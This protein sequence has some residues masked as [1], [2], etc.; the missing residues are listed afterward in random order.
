LR[1]NCVFSTRNCC[2]SQ[3]AFLQVLSLLG[4]QVA[5]APP[6]LLS[7]QEVRYP[8]LDRDLCEFLFSIP[9]EQVLR[10]GERRSLMRR[11]LI[12]IVPSE[13]L[14]RKRKAFVIRRFLTM[15]AE[16]LPELRHQFS[17]ALSQRLHYVDSETLL[18]TLT[19]SIHGKQ[20][21]AV[22]LNRTIALENWLRALSS[23]RRISEAGA[24]EGRHVLQES[25]ERL[26]TC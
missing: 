15:Y 8:Y 17:S 9:R 26:V 20:V 19:A 3:R 24:I 5:L 4:D 16:A 6:P 11:A 2:P 12:N 13:I 21:N 7:A 1:P 10:P 14:Q 25:D 23:H 22:Q 18:Q